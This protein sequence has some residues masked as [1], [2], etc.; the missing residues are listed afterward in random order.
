MTTTIADTT[1]TAPHPPTELGDY[2]REVD[3]WRADS[4]PPQAWTCANCW[5]PAP[6]GGIYCGVVVVD[7][8]MSL[9]HDILPNH[10]NT[11]EAQRIA[12]IDAIGEALYGRRGEL[13]AMDNGT[14]HH[15]VRGEIQG[16]DVKA[17]DRVEQ[18]G[19]AS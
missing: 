2:A 19:G 15:D 4:E 9:Y 1:S 12:L 13:L 6:V 16:V 5:G 18:P 7:S 11:T 10:D 3:T 17:F 8:E 14:F